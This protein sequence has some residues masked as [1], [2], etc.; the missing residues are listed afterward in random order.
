MK[1]VAVKEG[2]QRL[3]KAKAMK[4]IRGWWPKRQL[5]QAQKSMTR[6]LWVT[7]LLQHSSS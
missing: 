6:G 3:D 4:E 5:E 7:L 2:D 1:P